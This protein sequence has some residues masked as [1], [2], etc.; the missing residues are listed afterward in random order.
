[1]GAPVN[2]DATT[3]VRSPPVHSPSLNS[4]TPNFN[5]T[6]G[7]ANTRRNGDVLESLLISL[8]YL[9]FSFSPGRDA[10]RGH[11]PGHAGIIR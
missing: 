2:A 9:L 4:P 5:P 8:P 6:P 7:L 10:L 3:P 1:M 11:R